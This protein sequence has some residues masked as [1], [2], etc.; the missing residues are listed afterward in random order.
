MYGPRN[1]DSVLKK[2][3]NLIDIFC[4]CETQKTVIRIKFR[5]HAN[6]SNPQLF[7]SAVCGLVSHG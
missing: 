5:I 4:Y 6:N 3:I 1:L 7:T 2:E